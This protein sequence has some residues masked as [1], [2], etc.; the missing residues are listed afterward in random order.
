MEKLTLKL[1]G[2]AV[3]I[4]IIISTG[5]SKKEDDPSTGL[6]EDSF[7]NLTSFPLPAQQS[8]NEKRGTGHHVCLPRTGCFTITF[9][10]S[11]AS[12]S[13]CGTK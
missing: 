4:L 5:C 6:M 13:T 7:D 10:N 9:R 1:I 2:I 11:R 3:I 8:F 12:K